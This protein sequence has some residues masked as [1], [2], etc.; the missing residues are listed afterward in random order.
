MIPQTVKCR[1]HDMYMIFAIESLG[2]LFHRLTPVANRLSP[3]PR[4]GT[5]IH[6]HTGDQEILNL[7]F[8]QTFARKGI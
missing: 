8:L 5:C 4:L 6:S 3:L 2:V 7:Q 1:R